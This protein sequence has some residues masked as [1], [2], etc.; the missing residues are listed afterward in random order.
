M[1]APDARAKDDAAMVMVYGVTKLHFVSHLT[2]LLGSCW[3]T[4]MACT[5]NP[6]QARGRGSFGESTLPAC[7][8]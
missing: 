4:R 8:F 2:W 1:G 3:V 5:P 6:A 7:A